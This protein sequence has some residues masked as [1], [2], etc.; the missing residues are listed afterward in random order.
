MPVLE[1][2]D[3]NVADQ[4]S[5]LAEGPANCVRCDAV[6]CRLIVVLQPEDDIPSHLTMRL[7]GG[8]PIMAHDEDGWCVAMD[9][10]RMNCGIY[11]SRPTVC[12][13]FTMDGPYC[14]AVRNE[15]AE[16]QTRK[17]SDPAVTYRNHTQRFRSRSE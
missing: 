12:R 2:P 4:H 11:E 6:C 9:S 15:Y 7:P 5:L 8:L 13:R 10:A 3:R 1:F 14:R 16:H 17:I